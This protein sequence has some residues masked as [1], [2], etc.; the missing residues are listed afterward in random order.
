MFLD[1]GRYP[2]PQREPHMDREDL[3]STK[4]PQALGTFLL[5]G[6]SANP[7]LSCLRF[8]LHL[9]WQQWNSVTEPNHSI[10]SWLKSGCLSITLHYITNIQLSSKLELNLNWNLNMWLVLKNKQDKTHKCETKII[11]RC[12]KGVGRSITLVNPTLSP[13]LKLKLIRF[14]VFLDLLLWRQTTLQSHL[15]SSLYLAVHITGNWYHS[16]FDNDLEQ[17]LNG[18]LKSYFGAVWMPLCL[19]KV[20]WNPNFHKEGGITWYFLPVSW[21]D[22]DRVQIPHM[23]VVH[24]A[25]M[26][27]QRGAVGGPWAFLSTGAYL[28]EMCVVIAKVVKITSLH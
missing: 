28:E 24:S 13:Y 27:F 17:E 18:F 9:Q 8:Y 12:P 16:G 22:A 25:V 23:W 26:F 4:K 1:C 15:I 7:W 6:N 20:H 21:H 3:D 14:T 10:S 5:W 2:S 11:P 19:W